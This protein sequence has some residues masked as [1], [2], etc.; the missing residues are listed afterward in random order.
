MTLEEWADLPDEIEGELVDGYLVEEEAPELIHEAIVGWLIHKLGDWAYARGG[1]VAA[2]GAKFAVGERTGRRPDVTVFLP[3]RMPPGGS[4]VRTPP[5]VAVEIV[6]QTARDRRR[7]R[8]EKHAE[9][10]AFG[11]PWYWIVDW[12]PRTIEVF[13]RQADGR[14]GRALCATSGAQADVPGCAGLMLDLDDLWSRVERF[15]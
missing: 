1:I 9:Y 6:S 12:R 5:Y 3:E 2:S 10:A 15:R 13:A 4:L 14:Y 7:D 8:V 11:I